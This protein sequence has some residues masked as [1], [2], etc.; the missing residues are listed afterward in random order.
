VEV[1]AVAASQNQTA[2]NLKMPVEPAPARH[3]TTVETDGRL[4]E[5]TI[6]N[7]ILY[8]AAGRWMIDTW[9]RPES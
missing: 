1:V 8:S 6:R 2:K 9:L 4:V 7:N 5:D 3:R